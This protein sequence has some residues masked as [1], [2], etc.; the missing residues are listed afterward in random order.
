[1]KTL[2]QPARLLILVLYL[3]VLAGASKIALGVWIPPL[4]ETG[5]WF[6]SGVAAILLG[7]LLVTPYYTPPADAIS[8][9]VAAVVAM[10]AVNIWTPTTYTDFDRLLWISTL[11]FLILVI[12]ASVVSIVL[13][14]TDRPTLQRLAK[15]LAIFS[16]TVGTPKVVF[17]AV[18]LF[19]L[20]TFH[21]TS[22]EEA[23]IIGLAWAI[24]I[25]LRPLET[26]ANLIRRWR[27]IFRG[28]DGTDYLGEVVGR[29]HPNVFLIR[30]RGEIKAT[31][32]DWLIAWGDDGSPGLA[33]VLDQVGYSDGRWLR[34]IQ[35]PIGEEHKRVCQ[36]IARRSGLTE[37][38][39]IK[40]NPDEPSLSGLIGDT[41][42]AVDGLLGIVA[43]NSNLNVLKFEVVRTDLNLAEGRL[44]AAEIRKKSV[45]YQVIE[46]LTKEEIIQQKNTNGY[47]LAEAKKIGT[48]NSEES[49]FDPTNWVAA[50]NAP[51]VLV[52]TSQYVP[53]A[54][55][56]GHF[57]G[58]D[59]HVEIEN[60]NELVTHNTAIL[61]I[62][63][64]G[65]TFLALELVE[66]MIAGGIK[67]ICM[68]LTDQYVQELDLYYDRELWQPRTQELAQLGPPGKTNFQQNKEEGGSV[69][70]FKAAV[71][72]LV[73]D[74]LEP[75]NDEML[76]IFDPSSFD[77]WAQTGGIYNQ[78]AAMSSLTAAEITRIFTEATLEAL[79][80]RGMSD[81]AKCCVV[82]E[83]AHSLIPEW[84]AT[85][86]EGD[87]TASNATAKAILQGRK[88]GLGCLVVTQRTANVTKS[89]L[90]QCNSIFALRVFDAT[91]MEFLS[92]YIGDDY[93]AVL[94]TLED[95]HAVFFGRA[96][97]CREPVL[98]RLND[99]D[100]L[101]QVF[102]NANREGDAD[103]N[104][105]EIDPQPA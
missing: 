5:L 88:V 95:R 9:A 73:T 85:V 50:P 58:T 61:G 92:N 39:A 32:G 101:I 65:K 78:S 71:L 69:I 66:R 104:F 48:W 75:E 99:R 37:D 20:V 64:V 49:R 26:G 67:V 38:Y 44:V 74:F 84:N 3:V 24:L 86:G 12:G 53:S 47:V 28:A 33:V 4:N 81:R 105:Q 11:L 14:D 35:L 94:S 90:N 59:Y 43:P 68:D 56:I 23:M 8:N 97:S 93:S 77:V 46:G 98:V 17:S 13:K 102:R 82:F 6:Y 7:S 51:V 21:R 41:R 96:S 103:P 60:L 87:R 57:P 91:G 83:E 36:E 31:F 89:I 27:E 29:Q 2:G 1:M 54:D 62:L 79:Q 70:P 34:A 72:E 22:V 80:V 52:E 76:A 42:G 40:L 100:D 18:F 10:A 30:E 25:A 63:G 55:A 19:A 16:S 15:S 45:L